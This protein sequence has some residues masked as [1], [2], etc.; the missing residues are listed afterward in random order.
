[1]LHKTIENGFALFH[2]DDNKSLA[3]Q[4]LLSNHDMLFV[5]EFISSEKI[6]KRYIIQFDFIYLYSDLKNVYRHKNY[7]C[8]IKRIIK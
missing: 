8:L 5:D 4:F 2:N 7:I 6:P 3:M 1:M